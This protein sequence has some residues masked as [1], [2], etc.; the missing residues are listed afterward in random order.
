MSLVVKSGPQTRTARQTCTDAG[1]QYRPVKYVCVSKDML[2]RQQQMKKSCGKVGKVYKPSIAGVGMCVSRKQRAD[3]GATRADKGATRADKGATR[4]ARPQTGR[5][6]CNATP[7]HVWKKGAA[8]QFECV[9]KK[10]T[11]RDKAIA[12][13]IDR[14]EEVIEANIKNRMKTLKAQQTGWKKAMQKEVVRTKKQITQKE[15]LKQIEDAEEGL[16]ADP[17]SVVFKAVIDNAKSNLDQLT[18]K[19]KPRSDKG[20]TR[21]A[22]PKTERQQCIENAGSV[23]KKGASGTY[24]CVPKKAK[25]ASQVASKRAAKVASPALPIKVEKMME[26]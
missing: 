1:G 25:K 21:P 10:A 8:G 4:P 14:E 9:R 26:F 23:W 13:L 20:T 6:R 18:P 19:R 16:K 11:L 24:E 12:Q 17:S 15:L 3:K 5:Q 22:R 2:D 7:G